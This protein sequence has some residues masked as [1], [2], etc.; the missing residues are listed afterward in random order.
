MTMIRTEKI[1]RGWFKNLGFKTISVSTVSRLVGGGRCAATGALRI[2]PRSD[3]CGELS[4]AIPC[5]LFRVSLSK[6]KADIWSGWTCVRPPGLSVFLLS[7]GFLSSASA[8]TPITDVLGSVPEQTTLQSQTGLA[9]NTVCVRL[10]GNRGNNTP[11]QQELDDICTSM[12]TNA[13]LNEDPNRGDLP[14]G[15]AELDRGLNN[16]ELN[17]AVQNSATEEISLTG[18][19]T[20][21]TSQVLVTSTLSRIATLLAGGGGFNITAIDEGDHRSL[22]S[23]S[24][25]GS[26]DY[27][28]RGGAAGDGDDTSKLSRLGGFANVIGSFGE[29]DET[30]R[31]AGFDFNTIGVTAGLDYRLTDNFVFGGILGYSR[32]DSDFDESVNVRGG[33]VDADNYGIAIFGLYYINNFYFHGLGGYDRNDYDVERRIFIGT[34]T[35]VPEVDRTAKASPDADTFVASAGGG[36]DFN[37]NSWTLGPLARVQYIHS[38]LD[39]YEESGASALNLRVNSQSIKSLTTHIGAQ[40][41][42]TRGVDFGVLIPYL[43]ATWVH[44]FENDSRF[45]R[46]FYVNE[47]VPQGESATILGAET[48]DPDEDYAII[49]VGL[50]GVFAQRIQ[51]FLQYERWAGLEDI[52]DNVFTLGVRGSF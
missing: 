18:Q 17:S 30:D 16:E 11:I 12:V 51:G 45:I 44:E 25:G 19:T 33:G 8:Q 41:S 35:N 5:M 9:I 29:K 36:Y 4:L 42:Y 1:A 47:F 28:V 7:F 15:F 32:L 40:A 13:A 6:A 20:A 26:S 43:R 38:D 23:Y 10:V 52:E 2:T 48:D 14:A 37:V 22:F 27:G 3:N 31:E 21:R 24:P 34:N 39:S 50:S 46:S 49:G